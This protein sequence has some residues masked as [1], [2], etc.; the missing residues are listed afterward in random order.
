MPTT[1]NDTPCLT[2]HKIAYGSSFA[3]VLSTVSEEKICSSRTQLSQSILHTFQIYHFS[4]LHLPSILIGHL[5]KFGKFSLVFIIIITY[6]LCYFS[7]IMCTTSKRPR[8]YLYSIDSC[9][10]MGSPINH[11]MNAGLMVTLALLAVI[12]VIHSQEL[13]YNNK[14][15]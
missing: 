1:T 10:W 15:R 12:K 3:P 14:C 4:W 6:Y 5:L 8:D 2:K 7:I 9:S 11:N 13:L